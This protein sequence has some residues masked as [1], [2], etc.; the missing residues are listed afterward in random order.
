MNRRLTLM[1]LCGLGLFSLLT[2]CAT[3]PRPSQQVPAGISSWHGRLAVRVAA[4]PTS[5]RTQDQS[6]SAAFDL[7]GQAQQ[8]DLNFYTT[9]GS[10]AAAIH[11]TETSASVQARGETR[12][13]PSLDQLMRD[14]LGADVP[15]TA[16]FSW[17]AGQAQ[18]AAGWQVDL[19]AH[20][21]GKITARRL[22]APTAELR[23]VLEP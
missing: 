18:T 14:L 15:V 1:G 20:D 3:P 13:Y 8:G 7:S 6:F 11:W 5:T 10:T 16:L 23:V 12:H 17:L 19:S 22:T 21:Q 4:D 9:L 2:G